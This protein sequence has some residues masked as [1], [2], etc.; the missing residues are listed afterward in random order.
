MV[1]VSDA[2]ANHRYDLGMAVAQD[3]AHL[4]RAEIKDAPAIGVPHEAALGALGN[5]RR[6]L[7]AVAHE[8]CVRLLPERNIAVAGAQLAN[9]VHGP[10]PAVVPNSHNGACLRYPV[11]LHRRIRAVSPGPLAP[12]A[13]VCH[14]PTAATP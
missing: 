7:A 6:K 8:M 4:A 14:L 1:E 9:V 12:P 13:A 5:D 10:F 3:G 11:A 2:A